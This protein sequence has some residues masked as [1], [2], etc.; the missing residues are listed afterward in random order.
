MNKLIFIA[1][2]FSCCTNY[3][4]TIATD[5][6]SALTENAST[7]IDNGLQLETG[8]QIN[9]DYNELTTSSIPNFLMRYGISNKLEIRIMNDLLYDELAQISLGNW[10]L[11]TKI[12]LVESDQHTISLLPSIQFDGFSGEFS[13]IIEQPINTKIVGS[14][15]LS[16]SLGLG[17]TFGYT[18]NDKILGYSVLISK[19]L[20]DNFTTFIELYGF[21]NEINIDTGLAY[22]INDKLQFDTYFGT[23]LNT[24]MIFGSVGLSYL[25]LK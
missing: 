10:T 24:K 3:A 4:Q 14:W 7:L 21:N 23:G 5:R 12:Q 6:P 1:V 16:S 15:A 20:N 8:I 9:S 22:L 18:L 2:I 19:S 25:F 17:Y 11:G 13:T